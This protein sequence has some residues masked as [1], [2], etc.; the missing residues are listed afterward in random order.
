[1]HPR[2]SDPACVPLGHQQVDFILVNNARAFV[3][4]STRTARRS[5]STGGFYLQPQDDRLCVRR[6]AIHSRMGGSCTIE[7]FRKLVPKIS[8]AR[9]GPWNF[10]TW[11]PYIS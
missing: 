10:G 6:D 5:T 8:S 1:M 7:Q 9:G 4:S 11:H 2:R 3:P